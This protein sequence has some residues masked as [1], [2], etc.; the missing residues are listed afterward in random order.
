MYHDRS[1]LVVYALLV[2]FVSWK[3]ESLGSQQVE[4]RR[5]CSK[6]LICITV[7]LTILAAAAV[8]ILCPRNP[9]WQLTKL[10]VVDEAALNYFVMAFASGDGISNETIL[11]DLIFRAEATIKNPNVL[12]G[13]ADPGDFRVLFQDKVLGGGSSDTVEVPGLGNGKVEADVRVKL[14]PTLFNELTADVVANDLHT[15][16]TVQGDAMVKSIFGIKI[17]CRMKCDM[18]TSVSEIFGDTKH[19][20]VES[21]TCSFQYF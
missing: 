21:K 19:A 17:P 20:V 18:L 3:A 13:T 5:C 7:T 6:K 12:G 4:T 14:N 1:S 9:S 11:P 10:D 2:V 8:G 16:I 15:T